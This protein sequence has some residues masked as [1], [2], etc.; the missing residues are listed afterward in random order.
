MNLYSSAQAKSRTH[1]AGRAPVITV[2]VLFLVAA[3]LSALPSR[4]ELYALFHREAMAGYETV[5][6]TTPKR[7]PVLEEYYDTPSEP[8]SVSPDRT[9]Q[10]TTTPIRFPSE[11]VS[12]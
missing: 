7:S 2:A 10:A 9:T 6:E 12:L 3:L 1:V 11:H 8:S 4:G 5:A